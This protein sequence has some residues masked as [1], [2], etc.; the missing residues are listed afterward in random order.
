MESIYIN[1]K[2]FL[3][4]GIISEAV[5]ND[6]IHLIHSAKSHKKRHTLATVTSCLF[7]IKKGREDIHCGSVSEKRGSNP[8]PRPW[9]G[10]A[11]PTELFS[12]GAA[13]I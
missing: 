10:R 4:T 9:E 12:L 11:L 8:R 5:L 2:L 7:R 3:L 1:V 13:N 6:C